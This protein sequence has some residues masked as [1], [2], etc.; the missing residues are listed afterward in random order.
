VELVKVLEHL[1]TKK[2]YNMLSTTKKVKK[3]IENCAGEIST[4]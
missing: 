2:K 4:T 3:T 1:K